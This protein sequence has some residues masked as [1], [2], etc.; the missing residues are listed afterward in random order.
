MDCADCAAKIEDHLRRLPGVARVAVYFAAGKA[1][2]H[3]HPAVCQPDQ[4]LKAIAALGYHATPATGVAGERHQPSRLADLIRFAFMGVIALLAL[5]ELL[6]ERLGV[7]SL[8]LE[9]VPAPLAAGAVLIG[10]YPIFR[11]A[12]LGLRARQINADLLMTVAILAA[13]AIQE[14]IAA[15]LVVFFMLVAHSLEQ[16][17]TGRARRAIRAVMELAP[18]IAR[19]R[20]EGQEI[21]VPV[22]ELQVGDIVLVRPGERIPAD[23][24]VVEGRS[25]VNQSAITGESLPVEKGVGDPVFAGTLNERGALQLSATRV[26]RDS[27]LGRI[28]TLVE[29]AERA[30]A[31][32]QR[33]ADRYS[34]YFLPAVLVAAALTFAITHRP[35]PAIAVLI[36]ACPCA[37]ALATPLAV[38]ASVGAAARRGLLI[39]GGLHLEALAKVDVLVMDK[40]G[41]VTFGRPRVVRIVS[42]GDEKA[43]LRLA[44]SLEQFSEH[45]LA[46]AIVG[47]A[48]NRGLDLLAPNDFQALPGRGVE[49]LVDGRKVA[50]GNRRLMEERGCQLPSE[51]VRQLEEAEAAGETVFYVAEDG[52]VAGLLSLADT[53]RDEVPR[54]LEALRRLGLRLILLTG[55]NKHVASA[56]AG[57]LGITEYRASLLPEDKIAEIR[58]LQAEGHRVAMVGDGVNDAPALAQADV[59]IAMGVAGSDAALEAADIALMRDDWLQVPETIWLARRTFGTIKQNLAFGVLFNIFGV[60]LASV[61]ILTPVLAA[62]AQSLPDVAVFLNSSKLLR[63]HQP[64]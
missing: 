55:D 24:A 4:V 15:A 23:G 40:T 53:I 25:V 31:P 20:R 45:P 2:V 49:G 58:R 10:G 39:K 47:E 42:A 19:V 5:S 16:F 21:E 3:Y 38:V 32:V 18:E 54:A 48:R 35:V 17:T 52:A 11:R 51:I 59:G 1:A 33:F 14:F 62:A 57:R 13:L 50:V 27:T 34:T 46:G 30:R 64:D 61:G 36:V 12:F 44:A 60:G 63:I 37:V 6:L 7:G 22:E 41:T 9:R 8:A 26:G 29:E 56:L 28:I 43:L